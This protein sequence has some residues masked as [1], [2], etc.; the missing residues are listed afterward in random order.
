[1]VD[2]SRT[3]KHLRITNHGKMKSWVASALTFFE[4]I[5]VDK[6]LVIHT[7]PVPTNIATEATIPAPTKATPALNTATSVVPR[8]I[9]VVEIIKREY[10][11]TLELKHSPRMV[12]LHQYNEI[13][14]LEDLG[15][16][17][18][19]EGEGIAN[20][21]E[22]RSKNIILAMSG[23]IHT[24]LK[25]TPFMRVTLSMNELPELV[26]QGATYQPPTKRKF[27]KTAKARAKKRAK[28]LLHE[29]EAVHE[30]KLAPLAVT[31][32]A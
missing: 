27:S 19:E 16:S 7:L 1:M 10:I 11:K 3:I 23:K 8:L 6:R 2:D 13:G 22:E 25:Q 5:E 12:G 32:D 18:G 14:T 31:G 30:D 21:E 15:L 4:D 29:K 28:A 9:S 26:D 24:R 17:Q 20:A